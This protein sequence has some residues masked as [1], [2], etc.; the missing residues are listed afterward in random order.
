MCGICHRSLKIW[1]RKKPTRKKR[2][3]GEE[4]KIFRETT[5]GIERKA[6]KGD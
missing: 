3:T 5:T 4:E 6:N 2:M 1:E